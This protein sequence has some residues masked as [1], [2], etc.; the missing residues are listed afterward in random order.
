M[1]V[2][3]DEVEWSGKEIGVSIKTISLDRTNLARKMV[4]FMGW[5]ILVQIA[6][7]PGWRDNLNANHERLACKFDRR[8]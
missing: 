7:I 2:G 8:N 3:G 5:D 1:C 6:R 4:E